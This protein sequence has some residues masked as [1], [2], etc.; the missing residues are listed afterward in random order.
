MDNRRWCKCH[1]SMQNGY[2]CHAGPVRFPGQGVVEAGTDQGR[3]IPYWRCSAC[4]NDDVHRAI[5]HVRA[6]AFKPIHAGAL[7]GHTAPQRKERDTTHTKAQ[8][9]VKKLCGRCQRIGCRRH[10]EVSQLIGAH[11]ID[12]QDNGAADTDNILCLCPHDDAYFTES[13]RA[14][15]GLPFDIWFYSDRHNPTLFLSELVAA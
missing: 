10:G 11:I 5:F 1:H 12:I 3:L 6:G 9:E 14:G 7:P 2:M 8:N 15:N 13:K 4:D